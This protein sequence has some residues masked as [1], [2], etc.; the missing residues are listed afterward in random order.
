MKL[1]DPTTN[2]VLTEK[3]CNFLVSVLLDWDHSQKNQTKT[4]KQM[5]ERLIAVLD[6]YLNVK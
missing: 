4:E 1:K 5:W 6:P 2:I 3:E